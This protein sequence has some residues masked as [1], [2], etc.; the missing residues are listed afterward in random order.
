MMSRVFTLGILAAMLQVSARAY[1]AFLN[2][3]TSPLSAMRMPRSVRLADR[4]P[5]TRPKYGY[6]GIRA[7]RLA[8]KDE[9]RTWIAK[10]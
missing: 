7:K 5:S 9:R 8:A 3:A 10:S 1:S 2:P 6:A 4:M